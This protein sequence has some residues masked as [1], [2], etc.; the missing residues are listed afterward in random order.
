MPDVETLCYVVV[1]RMLEDH[2]LILQEISGWSAQ[3]TNRLVFLE[4]PKKYDM[5]DKT[6]VKEM[7]Q[8]LICFLF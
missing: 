5:F 8:I 1:E 7:E 4:T 2:Q 6:R 3:A